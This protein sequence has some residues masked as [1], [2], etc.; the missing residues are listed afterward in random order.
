MTPEQA[1]RI[2]IRAQALDGSTSTVLETV[3]RLGSLQLDPTARVAP[4]QLLVLW[5]RIGAFAEDELARLLAAREL[6]EWL[7]FVYPRDSLPALLS[8]MRRWPEGDG[9]RSRRIREWLGANASFR[10]YVLRELERNGPLPSRRLEDRSQAPWPSSGWTGNRNVSQMLHFL[11]GRGEVA[12]VGRAGKQRLFDLAE[13][14]YG[15]TG[16][17]SD[18]EGEAYLADR[19][20]RALG[21]EHRRGRWLVHPDADDGPVERTTLLSP[22][23]RLIHDRGRTEALF[24]FRYRLEIYVPKAERVHG[25]FVLPVLCGDRLVGRLDPELDRKAGV[26]RINAIHWESEPVPLENA[27]QSLA[28]FLGA[29][30]IEWP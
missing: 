19:R 26:L 5:S 14:W 22:F 28:Q 15:D 7:A 27:V 24:G 3:Q 30:R 1:R 2:A 25:Y 12:I 23:D 6:Y 4:T 10:R 29:G 11:T 9:A 20:F 17:L 21:V 13:R 8:R 16:A 18:A